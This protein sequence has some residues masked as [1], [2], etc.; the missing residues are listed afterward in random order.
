MQQTLVKEYNI[1][2]WGR[3]GREKGKKTNYILNYSN[4]KIYLVN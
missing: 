4:R 3:G 1:Y 2:I